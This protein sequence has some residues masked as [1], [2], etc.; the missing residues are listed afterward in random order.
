MH[1]CAHICTSA[2]TNPSQPLRLNSLLMLIPPC[3]THHSAQLQPYMNRSWLS[4]WKTERSKKWWPDDK[5]WGGVCGCGWGGVGTCKNNKHC[6]ARRNYFLNLSFN[7]KKKAVGIVC[8][9]RTTLKSRAMNDSY[10]TVN[11]I[12]WE[13]ANPSSRGHCNATHQC[14]VHIPLI[15]DWRWYCDLSQMT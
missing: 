5:S 8:E 4:L 3:Y 1:A 14:N 6:R 12:S 7:F 10:L 13:D 9:N 11:T 15:I 2:R